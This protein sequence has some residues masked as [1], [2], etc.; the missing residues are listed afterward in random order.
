MQRYLRQCTEKVLEA[1]NITT[2]NM[3]ELPLNIM[4][5]ELVLLGL[6]EQDNSIVLLLAEELGMKP[7]ETR[8]QI[9]EEIIAVQ[10]PKPKLKPGI[11]I[12]L[13][14]S[15]ELEPTFQVAQGL[16]EEFG[17][18]FVGTDTLLLALMDPVAGE[19]H[20]ILT[21]AGLT[22]EKSRPAIERMR[23][24]RKLTERNS[25]SMQ[26]YLS[27]FTTDL[28][29]LAHRGELDPVIGREK[30]IKRVIQILTRRKKNNPVLIGEPGVGKTVIAEGLAQL[31]ADADVPDVLLHKR[32]LSLNMGDVVAGAKFRGEFEERIKAIRDEIIEASGDIILFID[33]LHTVVGAGGGQGGVD[34]GN[35]LKPALSR[36]QLQCI[37][38]TTLDEYKKHVETDKALER[39]FQTIIVS[40]PTADETIDILHGLQK[41]YEDHH[42]VT[43]TPDA[44]DAAARLSE[45]YISDRFLPDKAIDLIDEAGSRK[46]LDSVYAPANMREIEKQKRELDE[47]KRAAFENEQFED[48][49]KYH[50]QILEIEE[51]LKPLRAQWARESKAKDLAVR[52]EDIARVVSDWTGIPV[53]RMLE[54]EAQKLLRMEDNLHKRVVSQDQ[55]ITAVSDAIRRNRAGLKPQGRPIGSFIFLG[56]TGVGKTELARALAEFLFDDENKLVRLDMS[57]YM[58]EHSVSKI[59]GS[60]PGYVGYDEG[61]QLTE[62]VRRNPYS[63]LLLDELEKA[64]PNVFN[65]FLQILDDGRLT[66][67]HGRTVNFANTVIIGTSNIGG[68]EITKENSKVGFRQGDDAD[69]YEDLKEKVLGEVKKVMKPEFMNRIDELIVFHQLSKEDIREIV[70]IQLEDLNRRLAARR[71]RINLDDALKQHLAEVGYNPVYGA[72][73]LKRTLEKLIENPLSIMLIQGK[74]MDGDTVSITLDHAGSVKIQKANP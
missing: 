62:I 64:H 63:V 7:A 74:L 2:M 20:R 34:A 18:K 25:E 72:R 47:K 36:G 9:V 51:Q 19:S 3:A 21:Q 29:E 39:R 45:R 37:G 26:D 27:E 41:R 59:T 23:K 35:L 54:T 31:I 28:T 40:E 65:I 11:E 32:V 50:Q 22:F 68:R 61:G 43:Y 17:D 66:D 53:T 6:A 60:P 46:F 5:S 8:N 70:D 48:A 71:L 10:A 56:P 33:E 1:I 15:G 4:T 55:A 58:E 57:E 69:S 16:A 24:G 38:A 13:E 14:A 12:H 73:P 49:A 67:A 42:K 44:L 30:E 52:E